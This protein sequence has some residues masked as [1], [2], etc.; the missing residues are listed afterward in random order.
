[1]IRHAFGE[2]N[3]EVLAVISNH[4]RLQPLVTKFNLPFHH[5]SHELLL[6]GFTFL[7]QSMS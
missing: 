2:L 3:A 5:L 1:L 6:I 7:V 4:A